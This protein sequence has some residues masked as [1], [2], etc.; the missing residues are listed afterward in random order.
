LADSLWLKQ[1]VHGTGTTALAKLA[2]VL[3]LVLLSYLILEAVTS[4]KRYLNQHHTNV[5][6]N[7]W[8]H[9]DRLPSLDAW[10]E[11]ERHASS[12][13]EGN[14][15]NIA[16]LLSMGRVYD[17]R[18]VKMAKSKKEQ[19]LYGLLSI[20]YY[21]QVTQLRPAWPYGWMNLALAKA[22]LGQFDR[23]FQHALMQL[24]ITGPWEKKIL[25]PILQLGLFSW[26]HLK[27]DNQQRLLDYFLQ[28]QAQRT[29]D[30]QRVVQSFGKMDLYCHLVAEKGQQASFCP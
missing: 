19:L 11:L 4:G 24:L 27:T 17:F 16:L 12:S 28:A 6:L 29:S 26:S 22:R 18:S 7:L 2:A 14:E 13:L 5:T 21:T 1:T 25:P 15:N 9:S 30:V 20:Q 23:D 8:Y 10:M 3:L